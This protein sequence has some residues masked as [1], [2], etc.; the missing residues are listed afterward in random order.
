VRVVDPPMLAAGADP[1][2]PPVPGFCDLDGI[3]TNCSARVHGHKSRL[4]ALFD[5][6][7]AHR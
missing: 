6:A 7:A 4:L 2:I 5:G 1:I 3:W